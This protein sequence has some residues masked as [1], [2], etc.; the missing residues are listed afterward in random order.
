MPLMK[1]KTSCNF[2]EKKRKPPKMNKVKHVCPVCYGATLGP[3]LNR[4]LLTKP[5]F[6]NDKKGLFNAIGL[7][8]VL[9]VVF[10]Y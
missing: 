8:S 10:L 6:A 3:E 2:P 9:F 4:P 1:G 7:V 5:I